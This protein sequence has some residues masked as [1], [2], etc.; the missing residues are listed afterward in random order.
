[1]TIADALRVPPGPVDLSSYDA[2][3]TPGF[4]GDKDDGKA[5]LAALADPLADLQERLFADGR[6]GGNRRILLVLQGMDTSGKGGVMRH[7]VGLFDPQG[8]HIKAFKAPTDEERGHDFLWRIEREL[9][10]VGMIGIFDRSH[11]EDVLIARVRG[12]ADDA[13]IE[14]RYDAINTIEKLLGDTGTT[15]VKCMLHVSAEEQKARLLERLENP[16]KHWKYNPGDIDERALWPDYEQAYEIALE[17]CN[18]EAAPWHVVPADRKWYRNWA[19]AALLHETLASFDLGWPAADF[20]VA[21][22]R[23]RLLEQDV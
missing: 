5:A 12:L 10:E 7:A 3:G 23:K 17:R 6:S 18:T 2:K 19:V 22:E 9:P 4:D 11:Y 16:E 20:D 14:R 8:V 13:E 1:M 21:T 15:V